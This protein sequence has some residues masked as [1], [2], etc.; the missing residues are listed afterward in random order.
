MK[1]KTP[2]KKPTTNQKLSIYLILGFVFLIPAIA[3]SIFISDAITPVLHKR[4]LVH[5]SNVSEGRVV[6]KE[7]SHSTTRGGG[8]STYTIDYEFKPI[9]QSGASAPALTRTNYAI[10]KSEYQRYHVGSTIEITYLASNPTIN[11]PSNMLH[12]M[13]ASFSLLMQLI[14]GFIAPIILLNVLHKRFPKIYRKKSWIAVPI[15]LG[16]LIASFA[17]GAMLGVAIVRGLEFI[18]F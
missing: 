9:G 6:N 11:A 17:V 4:Q 14:F 16:T 7:S 13:G 5:N 15:W 2:R 3:I 12:R 10:S 1:T 18:L 8:I